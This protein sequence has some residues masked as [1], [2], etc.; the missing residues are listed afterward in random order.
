[1][2]KLK[3]EFDLIYSHDSGLL[4]NSMIG[5]VDKQIERFRRQMIEEDLITNDGNIDLVSNNSETRT[6]SETGQTTK[7]YSEYYLVF[8][9]ITTVLHTS[10]SFDHTQLV[11]Y[12]VP[13]LNLL[14][15]DSDVCKIP[16]YIRLIIRN[17]PCSHLPKETVQQLPPQIPVHNSISANF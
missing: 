13:I 14:D 9:S 8:Y 17:E 1:M 15:A 7:T 12:W 2:I 16:S 5:V 11:M 3:K 6:V 10:T 4:I